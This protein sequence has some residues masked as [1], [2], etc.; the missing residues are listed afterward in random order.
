MLL[1]IFYPC[2]FIIN[3]Y[4]TNAINTTIKIGIH[5]GDKTHHQ[6]QVIT[7][8]SLRIINVIV[9][10]SKNPIVVFIL[11]SFVILYVKYKS[12]DIHFQ[13]IT[14]LMKYPDMQKILF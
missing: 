11:F 8:V 4:I 13:K 6:L 5:I 14:H 9:N 12:S 2:Y 10:K 3:A 7:F 1:Y